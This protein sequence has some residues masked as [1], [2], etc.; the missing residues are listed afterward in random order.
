MLKDKVYSNPKNKYDLGKKNPHA[1]VPSVSL[2][3]MC[4]AK[5]VY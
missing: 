5:W 3:L 1:V 4:S 2:A